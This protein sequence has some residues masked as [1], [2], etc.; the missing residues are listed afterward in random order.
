VGFHGRVAANK[1]KI[2]TRNPKHRL[3]W[4]KASQRSGGCY[5]SKG[6]IDSIL[7]AHDIGMRC[8]TRRG[9]HTFD[10][11]VYIQSSLG[12]NTISSPAASPQPMKDSSKGTGQLF[13]KI[14]REL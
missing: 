9:P 4:C 12:L 3:E 8:P 7:N 1:P 5:S 10:N 13:H 11:A 6:G 14:L 2:T